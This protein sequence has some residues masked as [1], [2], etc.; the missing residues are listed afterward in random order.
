MFFD[1]GG[2][3]LG[4]FISQRVH[5]DSVEAPALDYFEW[6]IRYEQSTAAGPEP[7]CGDGFVH[8]S[9]GEACDDG[10]TDN[11]DYCRAD[12][13]AINGFCGDLAI[14]ESAGEVCDGDASGSQCLFE[15]GYVYTP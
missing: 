3:L 5:D 1:N 14:Q 13:S 9:L 12:C 2:S 4:S 11:G 6:R 8:I 7:T 10:N 15:C